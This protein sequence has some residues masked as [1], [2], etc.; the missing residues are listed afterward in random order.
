M[1]LILTLELA[2]AISNV[3]VPSLVSEIISV[4]YSKNR[5]ISYD[6]TYSSSAIIKMNN[7]ELRV[8]GNIEKNIARIAI[9]SPYNDKSDNYKEILKV[10]EVLTSL[11][12]FSKAKIIHL[13]LI[14]RSQR[15]L[16]FRV[17]SIQK[18]IDV[19][20]KAICDV[21]IVVDSVTTKEIGEINLVSISGRYLLGIDI[22][23]TT[24]VAVIR[25]RSTSIMVSLSKCYNSFKIELIRLMKKLS[26]ETELILNY[27][28]SNITH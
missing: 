25:N 11:E 5:P 27:I 14:S 4:F 23:L 9:V 24:I 10:L 13:E 3:N 26:L 17:S 18:F 15:D 7:L 1:I 8:F 20:K 19:L 12:S 21:G 2:I 22:V 6:K 28:M 16:P